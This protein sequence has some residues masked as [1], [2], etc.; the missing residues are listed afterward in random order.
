MNGY[1][2]G[3]AVERFQIPSWDDPVHA[4][5]TVPLINPETT[6]GSATGTVYGDTIGE[7]GEGLANLPVTL[8]DEVDGQSVATGT[9]D[10]A[11]HVQFTSVRAGRY[12]LEI[13]AGWLPID[14]NARSSVVVGT[15]S[16]CGLHASLFY[17]PAP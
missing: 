6:I 17:V 2:Y 9:T 13:G 15:C 14:G 5:L 12:Q 3:D 4:D 16:D 10:S 8:I 1:Y 7:P 11:G